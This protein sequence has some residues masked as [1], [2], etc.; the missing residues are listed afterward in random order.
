MYYA[1][2][3][4]SMAAGARWRSIAYDCGHEVGDRLNRARRSK[5]TSVIVSVA[6]YGVAFGAA[7][8]AVKGLAPEH[9]LAIVAVGDLA[10]TIAV[11]AFSVLFD[12]SSLYDPYWSLSPAVIA[13][14]YLWAGRADLGGRQLLV[15]ALVLAYSARLTSNFYRGWPGLAHE[16][17]RYAGLRRR[18][19]RGYWAVSFFGVHL[20][21]TVVVYLGCLPLYAVM[22]GGGALNGLDAAATVVV[23]GAILLAYVADEQLR[24]FRRDAAL[25]GKSIQSGLWRFSSHPNY[26][27]EIATWWGLYLFAFAA[28]AHWWW[29][30]GGAV[31]ITLLFVLISVPLMERRA[32]ATR[33]GYGEYAART[34]MLLPSA[35][36]LFT[37]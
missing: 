17:F 12:N 27:G 5:S 11:F 30:G 24:R 35:S 10:A 19:P 23:L 14:Y 13:G 3:A 34:P 36:A 31:A 22:R 20:M 33:E 8:A 9:P 29:T 15:G 2:R 4:P 28:G 18:F 1:A 21:P 37:R 25:S 7:V 32:L 16:D 26:L 6:A